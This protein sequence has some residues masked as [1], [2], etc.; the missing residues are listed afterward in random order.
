[1]LN[2]VGYW[3]GSSAGCRNYLGLSTW[4]NNQT[5]VIN[6]LNSGF[7]RHYLLINNKSSSGR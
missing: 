5:P 1:M 6:P 2:F 7:S 3:K 4:S